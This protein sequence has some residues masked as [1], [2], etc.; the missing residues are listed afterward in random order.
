[1]ERR[2]IDE[3]PGAYKNLRQCD[4]LVRTSELKTF[5]EMGQEKFKEHTTADPVSLGSLAINSSKNRSYDNL[6]SKTI[7]NDWL[8]DSMQTMGDHWV[9]LAHQCANSNE[10]IE[11]SK[12]VYQYLNTVPPEDQSPEDFDAKAEGDELSDLEGHF[13]SDFPR[14][15]MLSGVGC[16]AH[17]R[18]SSIG[19]VMDRRNVSWMK[20][21]RMS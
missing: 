4:E 3:Y 7:R 6:A 15:V 20:I 19:R 16:S 21:V 17:I 14:G 2:V 5:N 10:V 18:F 12:K 1:M 13:G 11:L 8:P 9:D